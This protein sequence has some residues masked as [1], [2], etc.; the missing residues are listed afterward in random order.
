MCNPF[1]SLFF[2]PLT[3]RKNQTENPFRIAHTP[4]TT[5]THPK[6]AQQKELGLLMPKRT[7]YAAIKGGKGGVRTGFRGEMLSERIDNP[8]P[9]QQLPCGFIFSAS[10]N[11]YGFSFLSL[12]LP[13]F[14]LLLC[15]PLP[16]PLPLPQLFFSFIFHFN[17]CAPNGK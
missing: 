6:K 17:N 1:C 12:A 11:C 5:R 15:L 14:L 16:L 7:A 2:L 13:V 8:T 4:R 3:Q 10:S 9:L